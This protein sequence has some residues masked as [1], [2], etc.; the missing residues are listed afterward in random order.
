MGVAD[1]LFIG[2]Y[3]VF[4]RH[5][6]P[7]ITVLAFAAAAFVVLLTAACRIYLG[8]HWATDALGSI[9]LSLACSASSSSSTRGGRCGSARPQVAESDAGPRPRDEDERVGERGDPPEPRPPAAPPRTRPPRPAPV[10]IARFWPWSRPGRLRAGRRAR[11]VVIFYRERESFEFESEFMAALVAS[12]ADGSPCLPSCSTGSAAEIVRTWSCRHRH[13]RLLLLR[14]PWGAPYY[15][16]AA[17]ASGGGHPAHQGARRPCTARGHPR[18]PRLRLVPLGAQLQRRGHRD[19]AR[20]HLHAHV[21]LGRR[22]GLHGAHDAEPHIPRRALDL[23]HGRGHAH[24]RG[25]RGDRLGA[26]RVQAVPREH[27]CRTR[28]SGDGSRASARLR[29]PD[30]GGHPP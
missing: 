30:G 15:L 14:R 9:S 22:R 25:R 18:A 13:H 5:R 17:I 1:F 2:T 20:P 4:S 11:G 10:G 19:S 16:I 24:R 21:G 3:L 26:L 8:Y 28:R 23:R 29:R 6:R 12:R 27:G 7:V